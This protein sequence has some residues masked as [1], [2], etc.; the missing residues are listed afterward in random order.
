MEDERSEASV[1]GVAGDAKPLTITVRVK[2]HGR[3]IPVSITPESTVRDLKSSLQP[4][5]N[6]LPRGQKLIFEGKILNDVSSLQSSKVTDG[7]K[8]MM[9][10]SQ[11]LHQG[12]GP[13][14]NDPSSKSS[15]SSNN[16]RLLKS[17]AEVQ[18]NNLGPAHEM[19]TTLT[20]NQSDHWRITGVVALSECQLK[21]LPEEVWNCGDKIRVLD[22]NN[23]FIQEA[24]AKIGSLKSLYKLILNTNE[25]SDKGISWEGLSSLKSLTILSLNQNHLTTLPSALGSLTSLHQLHLADNKLANLPPELGLLSQLQILN[26]RNNRI[27]SVPSSIGNCSSLIEIDLSSNLLVGLPV[28]VGNL[29]NLKALHLSNNG[30]KSL[31]PLMFKMCTQ[32]STLDLH[33]TEITNDVLRQIEGWEAFDERRLAKHQKQL[34]FHVGSSGSFDEG[35][36]DERK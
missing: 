11:G 1:H 19:K 36:D 17:K 34:D 9:I 20:K 10:A 4:L 24:P 3:T 2:F 25:I 18:K 29:T 8:M 28:T 23:N 33:G 26:V 13:I 15:N 12:D 6:V 16:V 32:L 5:T 27:S 30:L 14:T 21:V 22:A 7:S 31:P 35:A